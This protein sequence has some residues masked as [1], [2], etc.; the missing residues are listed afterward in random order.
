[1]IN[2]TKEMTLIEA[3]SMWIRDLAQAAERNKE[4]SALMSKDAM[5]FKHLPIGV[6]GAE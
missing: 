6:I 1:M 5:E 3:T 4:I 2:E